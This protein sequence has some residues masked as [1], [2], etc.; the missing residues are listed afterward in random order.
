[1]RPC[2]GW[3]SYDL[4]NLV[5][6]ALLFVQPCVLDVQTGSRALATAS[7]LTDIKTAA[8]A[9]SSLR[10]GAVDPRPLHPPAASRASGVGPHPCRSGQLRASD[11]VQDFADG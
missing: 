8:E 1:M 4:I 7:A 6:K 10:A 3:A 5:I 11:R 9:L 2:T